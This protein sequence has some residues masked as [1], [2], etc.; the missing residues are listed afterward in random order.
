[1]MR[2]R[3][4]NFQNEAKID[5][6]KTIPD[7]IKYTRKYIP[8]MMVSLVMALFGAIFQIVGPDILKE[9]TNEIAKGLPALVNGMPVINAIDINKVIEIGMKMLI[10]YLLS[11]LFTFIT[12][13]MMATIT[14]EIS[15]KMRSDVSQKIN[16]LPLSYFD[17]TQYGDIISRVNNDV[18]AIGRTLNQSLDT[19]VRAITMFFGSIVMM[20]YN[21]W[22]LALVAIFST[23]IGFV[24]MILIMTKSQ[25]YFKAQQRTL[26]EINGH[27]E[28]IY[29]SLNVVKAYNGGKAAIKQ[30]EQIN[31][32]LYESGWIS[33]FLSGLMMPIMSFIG[34]FG[35]VAVAVVGA[36]LA[37]NGHITFGVVVAFTIYIRLFTQ[38]LSQ[39]AQALQQLQTTAAASER[40]F[41]L[42]NEKEIE[43]EKYKTKKLENIQGDVEFKNV[44][45]GYLP[46][47]PVIHNFSAK[48]NS[49]EKIAIVGPTGAGKTTLVNLL[50]RFY[51]VDSGDILIDGVSIKEATRGN[52]HDQFSMVLQDSWIF[53]GTIKENIIY[54]KEGVTDQEVIAA[55]KAVGLHHFIQTLPQ[56]YDT[57]LDDKASLSQGQKQLITIARSIV[58]DAPLLILDEA[59]SSVDT[60]TEKLVQDAMVRL[61][62]GRTSFVIAHRLS[63][64]KDS[65]SILVIN[66]GDIVEHGNHEELLHKKGFYYNLYNSQFEL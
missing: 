43:D 7:L 50:M 38:P 22:I 60:R 4:A 65:D 1:M 18:D 44:K 52:L 9:M 42:L 33:Q 23:S 8:F 5:F 54:S 28:E 15:R 66:E 59:T 57:V 10:L 16:V 30:F 12:G 56:G 13:F 14:A 58:K 35:Y 51:E 48:I 27:I 49:G 11:G 55:S 36:A 24:L 61:T 20:F 47:V 34:N 26:G 21:S 41:E 2:P 63:T 37:L 32:D 62:E 19:L 17:K 6:K 40:V 46:D 45:F 29:S 25:K 53:E 31:N 3:T 39:L 64:I